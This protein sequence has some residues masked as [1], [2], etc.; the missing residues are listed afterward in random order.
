MKWNKYFEQFKKMNNSLNVS[1]EKIIA[2]TNSQYGI[3][4]EDSIILKSILNLPIE[5][6]DDPT[7]FSEEKRKIKGLKIIALHSSEKSINNY[8]SLAL[9]K[10]LFKVIPYINAVFKV[11]L[12][13]NEVNIRLF[14]NKITVNDEYN[15]YIYDFGFKYVDKKIPKNIPEFLIYLNNNIKLYL[16]S[17]EC[18]IYGLFITRDIFH[19]VDFKCFIRFSQKKNS[20]DKIYSIP[21]RKK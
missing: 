7:I 15:K 13:N 17:F 3:F 20:K 5:I 10:G 16:F 14:E 12:Y 8:I 6:I 21:K 18:E 9:E 4:Y 1:C 2:K 19:T 11:S